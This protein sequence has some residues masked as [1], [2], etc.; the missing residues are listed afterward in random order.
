MRRTFVQ[1][2]AAHLESQHG[3]AKGVRATCAEASTPAQ[4]AHVLD[5]GKGAASRVLFSLLRQ[6]LLRERVLCAPSNDRPGNTVARY[7]LLVEL[8]ADGAADV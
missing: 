5:V 6:L 4:P 7:A 1:P 3:L 2:S 8:A